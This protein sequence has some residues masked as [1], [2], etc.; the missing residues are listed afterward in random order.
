MNTV[1]VCIPFPPP[2]ARRAL[3]IPRRVQSSSAQQDQQPIPAKAQALAAS[4]GARCTA[5]PFT[6]TDRMCL[7][8]CSSP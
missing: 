7:R 5:C 4:L 2:A 3:V 8:R 1:A 6:F